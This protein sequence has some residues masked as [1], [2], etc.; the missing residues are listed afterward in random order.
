[1][2]WSMQTWD[3]PHGMLL[4]AGREFWHNLRTLGIVA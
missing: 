4:G 1:M 2:G 3:D